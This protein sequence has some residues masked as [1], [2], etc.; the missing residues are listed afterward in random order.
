[1][2]RFISK[3]THKIELGE[4]EFIEVKKSLPFRQYTEIL[5]DFDDKQPLKF[6]LPLLEAMIVSWNLKDD[7]GSDVSVSP[8]SIGE[9]DAETVNQV[10][11][12]VMKFVMPEKKSSEQSAPSL[13][14]TTEPE[15]ER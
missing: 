5:G 14:A 13:P 4:G 1:M 10:I 6:A 12:E 8:D 7:S 11:T 3:E 2:S 9:L 15:R